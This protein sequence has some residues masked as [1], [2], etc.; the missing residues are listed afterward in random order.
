MSPKG[1]D[2]Q[3]NAMHDAGD[4]LEPEKHYLITNPAPLSIE[5][6]IRAIGN[7]M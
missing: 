7:I 4:A 1:H 5:Y 3:P 6:L 2:T